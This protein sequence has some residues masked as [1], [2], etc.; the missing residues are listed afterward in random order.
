V[1]VSDG[2]Y[3]LHV[4]Q[5]VDNKYEILA[6]LGKGG[7]GEVFKARHIK[8]KT[9]RVIKVMRRSLLGD[10]K[11]RSRFEREARI[12]TLVQHPNVAL[13]YDFDELPKGGYYMV[14]EFVDG[15][16]IRQRDEKYGRL[17]IATVL[18]VGIQVLAGLDAIHAAGLLHRDLS[19]D[20]VMVTARIGVLTAKIIDLGIAKDLTHAIAGDTTE[21]GLFVGNPRYASREQ[22]GT[23]K[24]GEVLDARADLYAFGLLLYEMLAGSHPFSSRTPQGYALKHLTE[25]PRPISTHD[26]RVNIPWDLESIVMKALEKNRENRFQ[27]AKEFSAALAA[28]HIAPPQASD[29]NG[30]WDETRSANDRRAFQRFLRR[31]PNG[32]HAREASDRLNDFVV[33]DEVDELA[34]R[35]D[36]SG[37]TRLAEEYADDTAVGRAV[38]AALNRMAD[39]SL[40]SG[41]SGEAADWAEACRRTNADGWTRYLEKHPTSHRR[42]EAMRM[43][44]ECRA[45]ENAL[46]TATSTGWKTFI[47]TWPEGKLKRA[48]QIQLQRL[49]RSV[50]E[51]VE[52]TVLDGDSASLPRHAPESDEVEAWNR[53]ISA[54]TR[55]AWQYYLTAH[56]NS[57]R[58]A[59]ARENLAEAS[60]FGHA[61]KSNTT[62]AWRE[63]IGRWPA[64]PHRREADSK[65]KALTPERP[66]FRPIDPPPR[67]PPPPPPPVV[68]EH[69]VS[70][71]F[72]ERWI[73]RSETGWIAVVILLGVIAIFV[74]YVLR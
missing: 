74:R 46:S 71:T 5:V 49:T 32:Q 9:L 3:G 11:Y 24:K 45:F 22:L 1:S 51:P 57:H 58:I 61:A 60:A 15:L 39:E 69:E 62:E 36:V 55:A 27:T 4:G 21:T 47:Q 33:M 34:R 10:E 44:E 37:L 8:L 31:F 42:E 73:M 16:T 18:D 7:M 26:S 68:I 13:T 52:L 50:S 2:L 28:I 48:A 40:E 54:G 23:L 65:L 72:I 12:A 20:N 19:A 56:A 43:K 35:G 67:T 70:Q 30:F 41:I 63:Y 17:P 29:E 66:K 53:A 59:K 14:C 25:P 38:Q 6:L 64:G